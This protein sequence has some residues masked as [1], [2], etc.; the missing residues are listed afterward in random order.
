[1][2]YAPVLRSALQEKLDHRPRALNGFVAWPGGVRK[3][4]NDRKNFPRVAM[5]RFW[6][7]YYHLALEDFYP[8]PETD[9]INGR[10]QKL[11]RA[12]SEF[13]KQT[14]WQ[15]S[16]IGKTGLRL[17]YTGRPGRFNL[18]PRGMWGHGA[19]HG[20]R[21]YPY[22]T[23]AVNFKGF[24][25][26]MGGRIKVCNK[27]NVIGQMVY[28]PAIAR[29]KVVIP[30][31]GG[32]VHDGYFCATDTGSPYYIRAD[33][34]DMFVGVHGGGNPFL[35]PAR[36]KNYLYD[37]GFKSLLP[38]DWRL[39]RDEKTR[40]WCPVSRLPRN[41]FRPG[42]KDCIHDYHAVAPEKSFQIEA[43]FRR[44]GKPLRCRK[45]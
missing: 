39:W 17:H 27:R 1:M 36:R 33:R 30:G 22:R 13:L 2:K 12:S 42:L 38:S 35:P 7:T 34:I 19:G 11:G 5:G 41:P 16:G 28:I 29:A 32:Q 23:I 8:G 24:C 31:T 37:A 15:G 45:G 9:I 26:K 20:Y 44:D 14:M 6:P 10:G 3:S 25:K 4:L 21:V 40:V 43:V 18:Y